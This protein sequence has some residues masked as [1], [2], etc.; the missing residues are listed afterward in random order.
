MNI[1]VLSCTHTHLYINSCRTVTPVCVYGS[2]SLGQ[3]SNILR[4]IEELKAAPVSDGVPDEF[5]CPITHE[6][7]KEPVMAAGRSSLT[8]FRGTSLYFSK[9]S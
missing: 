7:M 3:R 1:L 8:L 6:V 4:K 5:L 2:E 9:N